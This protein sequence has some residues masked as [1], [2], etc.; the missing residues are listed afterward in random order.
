MPIYNYYSIK[1]DGNII[2]D[3]NLLRL[4][5]P[6]LSVEITIPTALVQLYNQTKQAIPA[7][8]TGWAI[9]D[10]GAYRTCI[11][12]TTIQSLGVNAVGLEDTLT[13]AGRKKQNTY[14]AHFKFPGTTIDLD[15]G[16]VIG[17]DLQGQKYNNQN[18]IAL[19]GRDILSA[20]ILIYNGK[21]GMYTLSH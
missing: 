17:A 6:L 5:G 21:S 8:I 16:E 20:C 19:V 12:N 11:D 1:P 14:P 10:T 9:L 7:P 13:P 3:P 15:F 4:V 2:E 18:I